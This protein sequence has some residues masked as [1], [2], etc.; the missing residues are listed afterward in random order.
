MIPER[1]VPGTLEW[2]LY[3]H[4]HEQR[5][6]FFSNMYRGLD[7][8]DAACGVGYGSAIIARSGARSVTGVDIDPDAVG[9]AEKHFGGA[10]TKYRTLSVE[11]LA[12]LG[13]SFDLVVS[14]ETIEH[15]KDPV[16]FIRT[17]RSVL[18]PGGR[19]VCSTPNRDFA[20]KAEGYVNPYHLS[21]LSFDEFTAAFGEWFAIDG[22][23]HQSH[24]ESYRRH[25]QLLGEFDRVAKAVRFSK[26]LRLENT[27]R[28]LLGLN[29]WAAEAPSPS[30][31]RAVPGDFVIEP[32][33][34]P[35][36]LHLTFILSGTV[37]P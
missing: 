12:K 31:S 17:V 23:Y 2:D 28:K 34:Q 35:Q 15:L 19:F 27:L 13:E 1:L 21:E 37:K 9:Y 11:D 22:R 3:R 24:S 29:R 20:G 6:R 25:I 4:E 14:F 26:L 30:L 5:Y 33:E 18:R 10:A 16:G 36:A 7:V 32:V 8:L